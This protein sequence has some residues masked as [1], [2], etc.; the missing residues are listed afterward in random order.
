[1]VDDKLLSNDSLSASFVDITQSTTLQIHCLPPFFSCLFLFFT[2]S[3][4]C[5]VIPPGTPG[6]SPSA[7]LSFFPKLSKGSHFHCL[8]LKVYC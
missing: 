7:F 3:R 8:I 2:Q 6:L 5:N 4:M 1:M